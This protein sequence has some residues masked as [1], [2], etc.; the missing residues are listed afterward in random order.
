MDDSS[1]LGYDTDDILDAMQ[2]V[3]NYDC[4]AIKAWTEASCEI[5]ENTHL[6]LTKICNRIKKEGGA[7]NEEELK[8]NFLAFLFDIAD[9]NEESKI[10]IFYE[11][12]LSAVVKGYKLSVKC[13][14]LLAT[15]KGVGKPKK[16]YFFLQ[17]FKK[18]K[19]LNTNVDY[20]VINNLNTS[21]ESIYKNEL[22]K[23]ISLKNIKF[24][25]K[26]L[27]IRV[28]N[29]N[30]Y[31]KIGFDA[32]PILITSSNSKNS[33]IFIKLPVGIYFISIMAFRTL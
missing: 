24:R 21:L 12:P 15:P 22:L 30:E 13:D 27:L 8:M 5:D 25:N 23:N 19:D 3:L 14:C 26:E 17:E 20:F 1:K 10:K 9:L 7:W 2:L 4:P 33:E 32:I 28:F 29:K 31:D 6:F 11:R 18:A 16:P